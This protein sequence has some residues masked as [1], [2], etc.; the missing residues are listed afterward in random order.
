MSLLLPR[1]IVSTFRSQMG[2]RVQRFDSLGSLMAID[3]LARN[4]LV[5]A[6]DALCRIH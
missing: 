6:L 4:S 1:A 3:A 5:S 2:E